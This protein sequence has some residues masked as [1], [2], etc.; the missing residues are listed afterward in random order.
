MS[1]NKKSAFQLLKK[2]ILV[3]L[4]QGGNYHT[5]GSDRM[6][7]EKTT[8]TPGIAGQVRARLTPSIMKRLRS[9]S[10]CPSFPSPEILSYLPVTTPYTHT[11]WRSSELLYNWE[12]PSLTES[13]F[14]VTFNW[15]CIETRGSRARSWLSSQSFDLAGR[16]RTKQLVSSHTPLDKHSTAS[17]V[18]L[19]LR[20]LGKQTGLPLR[21]EKV[22]VTSA[23]WGKPPAT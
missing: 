2:I 21:N 14:N 23:L 8:R 19:R 17:F 12:I 1:W 13:Q 20:I 4:T 7:G 11:H 15:A 5:R 9:S 22:Q 3:Y 16:T 6:L 18:N 10:P